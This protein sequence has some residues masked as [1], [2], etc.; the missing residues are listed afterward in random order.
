MK[1]VP[2]LVL[3]LM[4]SL[5]LLAGCSGGEG[6]KDYGTEVTTSTPKPESVEQQI[7]KIKADTHMPQAAKDAAI[8]GLQGGAAKGNAEASVKSKK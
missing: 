8:A 3:A 5:S 7:E 2:V 4:A 1:L 6:E